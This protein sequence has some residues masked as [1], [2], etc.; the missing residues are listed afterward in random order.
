MRPRIQLSSAMNNILARTRGYECLGES[1]WSRTAGKKRDIRSYMDA[2]ELYIYDA[3]GSDFLGGGVTARDVA[4][5]LPRDKSEPITV[6]INSPGGDVFDG[7][8]IY[9]LLAERP[10]KVRIDA[11]AASIASVIALAG[12]SVSMVESGEYMIHDPWMIA[13]GNADEFR[14]F[15]TMLDGVK[16]RLV[17]IYAANSNETPDDLAQ[18]MSDET[19]F[20]AA[21]AAASGFVS[22]IVPNAS[23]KA[24]TAAKREPNRAARTRAAAIAREMVLIDLAADVN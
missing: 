4:E 19:T 22:D 8:A 17:G 6:R 15:A 12:S 23:N 21:E 10:V 18:L 5:M 7:I 3:I 20:S 13:A 1:C 2:G 11:Q 16:D 9:N 14:D 24:K